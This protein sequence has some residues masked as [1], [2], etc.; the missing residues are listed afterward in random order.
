MKLA[1][2]FGHCRE[3]C[4]C[5]RCGAKAHEHRCRHKWKYTGTVEMKCPLSSS[6]GGGQYLDP[7]YGV[8]CQF[9]DENSRTKYIYICQT[10]GMTTTSFELYSQE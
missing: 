10:C 3:G 7:C 9:C 4:V 2:L 5:R 1:C 8:D 6:R